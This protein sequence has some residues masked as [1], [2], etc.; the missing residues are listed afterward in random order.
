MKTVSTKVNES[1]Y[2]KLIESCGISGKCISEKVRNLIENSLEP[3]K[4]STDLP[5]STKSTENS[6]PITRVNTIPE[7]EHKIKTESNYAVINGQYF[8]KC[9]PLPKVIIHV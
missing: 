7:L 1:V 3:N 6:R 4:E 5:K 9:D 2:Q 8:K